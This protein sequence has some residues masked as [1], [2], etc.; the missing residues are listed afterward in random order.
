METR[1]RRRLQRQ[2]IV[3]WWQ[4]WSLIFLSLAQEFTITYSARYHRHRRRDDEEE[5]LIEL[6]HVEWYWW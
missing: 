5:N 6:S 2:I 1:R 3:D 4:G